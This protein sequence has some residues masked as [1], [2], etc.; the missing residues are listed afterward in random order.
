MESCKHC[1]TERLPLT[2][3]ELSGLDPNDLPSE[4]WACSNEGCNKKSLCGACTKIRCAHCNDPFCA[5]CGESLTK[6]RDGRPVCTEC[7][8]LIAALTADVV[9]AGDMHAAAT[10]AH[11]A[12]FRGEITYNHPPVQLP[13]VFAQISASARFRADAERLLALAM[14]G[15]RIQ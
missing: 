1:D 7:V 13:S 9:T 10:R 4:F 15:G 8:L 14:G 5:E 3:G 6:D 2:C 12:M 11:V